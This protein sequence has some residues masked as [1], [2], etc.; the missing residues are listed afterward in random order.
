MHHLITFCK[1]HVKAT[2]SAKLSN[3]F[4]DK[5]RLL[6]PNLLLRTKVTL[7]D[8]IP[9]L[10]VEHLWHGGSRSP[11]WTRSSSQDISNNLSKSN[12]T[13]RKSLKTSDTST[14]N[15]EWLLGSFRT[16]VAQATDKSHQGVRAGG[17]GRRERKSV[18]TDVRSF[19]SAPPPP[20]PPPVKKCA[21]MNEC[22]S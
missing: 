7:D 3:L 19:R 21:Q 9:S 14:T 2:K 13:Q 20:P 16:V 1:A 11:L 22:S 15:V 18:L 6:V 5:C 12:S 17:E 4:C 10:G 8:V